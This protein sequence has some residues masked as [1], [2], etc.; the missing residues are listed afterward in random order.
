MRKIVASV[1]L[2]IVFFLFLDILQPC[3]PSGTN[4]S[5]QRTLKTHGSK[6]VLCQNTVFYLN[7]PIVFTKPYQQIYTKGFPRDSR[8]ALLKII[9]KDISI[10]IDGYNQQGIK[11]KNITVDGNRRKLG[12]LV[13]HGL[14]MVGGNVSNQEVDHIEAFDSRSWTTVHLNWGEFY[15][16]KNGQQHTK[17]KNVK[18]TNNTIGPSGE[19]EDKKWSDGISLQCDSSVISGNIITDVTD[20]GIIIFGAPGSLV[21]KNVIRA[22]KKPLLVGIGLVD[23]AFEGNYQGTTVLK[24]TIRADSSYI[25]VGIAMGPGVWACAKD[26]K[27]KINRGAVIKQN[28][29]DGRYFGY[30][31]AVNGV[32]DFVV[33]DNI[34]VA[35]HSGIPQKKCDLLNSAPAP[36]LIQ[37]SA[38]S[39][40]FQKEFQDAH[41]ESIFD[42]IPK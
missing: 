18:V 23:Y 21:T 19:A 26:Q 40:R 36:F 33:E 34:S 4:E 25:K 42:V 30:G 24:N 15:K 20:G 17:C 5:I 28:T 35:K 2:G 8:K 27:R 6:A 38:S 32:K 7:R 31:Y 14:I 39:G 37:R 9:N 12:Q 3:I 22:V 10:A 13:S 16:D 29:L 41:L 1:V 11:I